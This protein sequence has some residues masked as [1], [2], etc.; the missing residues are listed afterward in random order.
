MAR[1]KSKHPR[2]ASPRRR[3]KRR[4]KG[5]R[6][7]RRRGRHTAAP[8]RA[9][10]KSARGRYG[11]RAAAPRRRK[12]ARR[13]VSRR[14]G[15]RVSAAKLSRRRWASGVVRKIR[16]RK[17]KSRRRGPHRHGHGR[18]AHCGRA[19]FGGAK[20]MKTHLRKRHR[21][22]RAQTR[23]RRRGHVHRAK[24]ASTRRWRKKS[25]GARALYRLEQLRGRM[26]RGAAIRAAIDNPTPVY[27]VSGSAYERAQH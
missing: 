17:S 10:R 1:R 19:I 2:Y 14:R 8:R 4:G 13:K 16:S 21:R 22:G 6:G 25:Y 24:R 11:K 5:K 20:G 26:R 3:G 27:E 15:R 18:C 12:T 23:G 7:V 9:R